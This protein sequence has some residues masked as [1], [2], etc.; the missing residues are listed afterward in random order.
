MFTFIVVI[1]LEQ[2]KEL[3]LNW[4]CQTLFIRKK[5]HF[6]IT[7]ERVWTR[8]KETWNRYQVCIEFSL[9]MHQKNWS[10]RERDLELQESILYNNFFLSK[11]WFFYISL[12]FNLNYLKYYN[13]SVSHATVTLAWVDWSGC[14][15]Q[16][17]KPVK[18]PKQKPG[19]TQTS[20][21]NNRFHCFTML[22]IKITESSN[23]AFLDENPNSTFDSQ[24]NS[25]IAITFYRFWN[26]FRLI[27]SC[28]WQAVVVNSFTY[29]LK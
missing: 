19:N 3:M 2:S 28:S 9:K 17:D 5:L 16:I 14:I 10:R 13:L 1:E 29:E 15:T 4:C 20:L 26:H 8:F 27:L 23:S 24:L 25:Q 18:I 12:C 7:F 11:N 21:V 22:A 6:I